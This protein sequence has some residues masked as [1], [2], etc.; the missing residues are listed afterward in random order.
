MDGRMDWKCMA[1]KCLA[2]GQRKRTHVCKTKAAVESGG[3]AVRCD[4][5]SWRDS[6]T[7]AI[8]EY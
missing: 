5:V 7:P 3:G 6:Y 1:I 2:L 4:A 8:A